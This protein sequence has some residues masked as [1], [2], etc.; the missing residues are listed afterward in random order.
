MKD[1]QGN[2]NRWLKQAEFDLEQAW[3]SLR[4]GSFAYAAFF[5]EQSAQKALKAFLIS[6]GQRFITT[7]S[8]GELAREAALANNVFTAL[9]DDGKKLDRH[10]LASRYPDALP[11]PAIPATSY[12]K[13]DAE[14]ATRI[15]SAI[16]EMCRLKIQP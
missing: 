10:Y 14:E 15:A 5:A 3:R 9:I 16:F 1:S 11:A 7:H 6:Q 2:A 13:N 4:D 8:V 12:T